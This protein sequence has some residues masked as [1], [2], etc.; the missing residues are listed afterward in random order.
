MALRYLAI[1]AKSGDAALASQGKIPADMTSALVTARMTVYASASKDWLVS[2]DG[3]SVML[4]HLFEK[5]TGKPVQPG[6]K[7]DI[8]EKLDIRRLLSTC[9]GGY[10]VLNQTTNGQVECFRDPSGAL[11]CYVIETDEYWLVTS[12]VQTARS[13]G[14]WPP[15]IDWAFLPQ[16]LFAFDRRTARTGLINVTELLAGQSVTLT[17]ATAITRQVWSPWDYV[18]KSHNQSSEQLAGQLRETI[19]RCVS[20]WGKRFDRVLL[21]ASGGLDSSIIALCLAQTNALAGCLTMATDEPEGD[22]RAYAR[23]IAEAV[24]TSLTEA[25]HDLADIDVTRSSS[26]HLPRPIQ[27][28]FGQSEYRTKARLAESGKIDAYFTGIGGDNVFCHMRSATPVIDRIRSEGLSAGA[29]QTLNDVCRL[30]GA[31]AGTAV[32]MAIQRALRPSTYDWR[33]DASYLNATRIGPLL[34][35]PWLETPADAL[36]GKAVHIAMLARIQGTIDG[37]PRASMG[38]MVNPL[39]SQPIVE[40]CL[41]IPTWEW[42]EGG[43]DRAVARRAFADVMPPALLNRRSKGGPDSFAFRIVETQRKAIRDQL[44]GGLLR[45]HDVLDVEALQTLFDDPRPI[46]A[47]DHIRLLALA[48]AEAWARH[49]HRLG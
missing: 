42:C 5:N 18:A 19:E 29:I 49:W 40:L 10:V 3:S 26:A 20:A 6:F 32:G 15:Q 2:H 21:G 16:H 28:A 47:P 25:F 23:I 36:P 31:S 7:I 27:F 24:C 48:E 22:E 9:F 14:L 33:G 43:Q 35:H 8:S 30:T 45:A 12:D 4:G 44:L 11:P 1:V 39:L 34:P 37:F 17:P 41:S 46:R 38:P 13:V